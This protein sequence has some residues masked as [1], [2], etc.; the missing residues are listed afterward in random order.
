MQT[1]ND[2]ESIVKNN[3]IEALVGIS[4]N[5]ILLKSQ[6]SIDRNDLL[7]HN[8]LLPSNNL[9]LIE[10]AAYYD[11]YEC[12]IYLFELFDCSIDYTNQHTLIPP[13]FYAI[14]GNA[15]ECT[16]YLLDKGADVNYVTPGTPITALFLAAHLESPTICNLLIEHGAVYPDFLKKTRTPDKFM[17]ITPAL[18]YRNFEIVKSLINLRSKSERTKPSETSLLMKAIQ[19]QMYDCVE[20]L[21]QNGCDPS[22]STNN[23]K[24]PLSLACFANREDIVSLL[25]QYAADTQAL[26]EYKKT[27]LHLAAATGNPNIIMMAL[28]LGVDIHKKDKFGKIASFYVHNVDQQE[29]I[30]CFDLLFHAGIDIN[31]LCNGIHVLSPILARKDTLPEL[32]HYFLNNGADLDIQMTFGKTTKSLYDVGMIVASPEI[33]S[34][35]VDWRKKKHNT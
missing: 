18:K 10:I 3:D 17:P 2:K 31:Q 27:F 14:Y 5:S 34:I 20:L 32:V 35:L 15:V 25:I 22:A 13:L 12:L 8:N 9:S 7:F 26:F 23:G 29:S 28:D 6:F 30:Q 24:A 21:L 16:M 1:N 11:S 33:K 4:Q 19:Y